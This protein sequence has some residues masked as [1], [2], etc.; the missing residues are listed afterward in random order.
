MPPDLLTLLAI[1]AVEAL[2]VGPLCYY[3]GCQVTREDE[4]RWSAAVRQLVA[5]Y[6]EELRELRRRLEHYGRAGP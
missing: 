1:L 5:G 2:T 6:E 3:A 4:D